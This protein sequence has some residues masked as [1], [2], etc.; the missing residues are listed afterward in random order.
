MEFW[1]HIAIHFREVAAEK[2]GAWGKLLT[3]LSPELEKLSRH[4]PIGRLRDDDDARRDIIAKVIARLHAHDYRT[5]K[6]WA[7][8]PEPAPPRAWIRVL[9][10]SAAIDVMRARPE[11]IRA[12]E[13]RLPGWFS[14]ATLATQ[15][16]A[17]QADSLLVKQKEVERFMKSAVEAAQ[18]ELQNH[19]DEA[20]GQLAKTWKIPLVHTRRLVKRIDD[21]QKVLA[22]VLAGHSYKEVAQTLELSRREVE[23]IVDYIEEFFHARGFA[24]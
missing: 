16:G 10:R 13:K 21:Y 14:L 5:I 3:A 1:E 8:D 4:Q 20:A 23:L 18:E 9:V 19:G 24:A 7:A 22:M 15:A 2:E 6:N 17:P 11:Y 12:S